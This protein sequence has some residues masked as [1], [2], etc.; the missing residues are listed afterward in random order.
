MDFLN[1]KLGKEK[2]EGERTP[3]KI[4]NKLTSPECP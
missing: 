4:N 3:E 1:S 2:E